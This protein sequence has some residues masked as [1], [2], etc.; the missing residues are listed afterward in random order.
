ML[1]LGMINLYKFMKLGCSPREGQQDLEVQRLEFLTEDELPQL[2]YFR[3]PTRNREA[4]EVKTRIIDVFEP[5]LD[6]PT[7]SE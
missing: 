2:M 7:I 1:E 4:F 3:I 5:E 6:E